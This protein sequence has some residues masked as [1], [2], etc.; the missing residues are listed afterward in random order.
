[1]NKITATCKITQPQKGMAQNLFSV[2]PRWPC[3]SQKPHKEILNNYRLNTVLQS[4]HDLFIRSSVIWLFCDPHILCGIYL[5]T[6][7]DNVS[8]PT[9]HLSNQKPWEPKYVNKRY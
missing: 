6:E 1:M 5:D 4:S 7:Y 3:L 9:F 2:G 8:H